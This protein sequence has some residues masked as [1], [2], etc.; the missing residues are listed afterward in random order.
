MLLLSRKVGQRILI[1]IPASYNGGEILINTNE[2]FIP[3]NPQAHNHPHVKLG[4]I[5]DKAI[6]ITREETVRE[7][8][9]L[10]TS[11]TKS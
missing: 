11:T 4:I 8:V 9:L 6:R 7:P 2:I 1:T 3:R 5:A 10:V